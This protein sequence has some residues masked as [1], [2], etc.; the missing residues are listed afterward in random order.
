VAIN[1]MK[2]KLTGTTPVLFHNS[3]LVNPFNPINREKKKL[4][5]K[6]TKQTDEDRIQVARLEW[7]GGWYW[8]D[9]HGPILPMIN[10]YAA[11]LKA[12]KST[13]NGP[14]VDKGVNFLRLTEPLQYDGPRDLDGLW[15]N[16]IGEGGDHPSPYVDYQAV[17]QQAVKIMRCRP[18][19]SEWELDTVFGVDDT[20]IDPEAFL[21]FMAYAGKYIGVG[22]FR[23]MYG[24]F[25]V[26]EV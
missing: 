24:K 14:L 17:G 3:Q 9:E 23:A 7:T 6:R 13:R 2:L 25:S 8:N 21:G 4:T 20:V 15:G 11:L 22:D 18:K 26:K 12:A 1:D 19:L 16:G 10:V 5:D